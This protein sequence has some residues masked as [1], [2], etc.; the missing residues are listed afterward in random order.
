MSFLL[1]GF[2]RKTS[3]GVPL[4][5]SK[6]YMSHVIKSHSSCKGANSK[7]NHFLPFGSKMVDTSFRYFYVLDEKN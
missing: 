1:S 7:K 5:F 6:P 3:P 4:S 2:L